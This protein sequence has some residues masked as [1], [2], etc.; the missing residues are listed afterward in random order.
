MLPRDVEDRWNKKVAQHVPRRLSC[1][2]AVVGVRRAG[3]LAPALAAFRIA[4]TKQDVIEMILGVARCGEGANQWQ[5][6]QVHL[7]RLNGVSHRARS[8]RYRGWA[9]SAREKPTAT[10]P[11]P[12]AVWKASRRALCQSLRALAPRFRRSFNRG[13][14]S[15]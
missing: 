7:D 13:G 8:R 15:T 4:H 2:R 3:A 9:G 14:T 1:L 5:A 11:A 10:K 6:H 12:N